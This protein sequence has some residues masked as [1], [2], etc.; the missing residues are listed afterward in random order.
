V[1]EG[2]RRRVVSV[3]S[4]A[5]RGAMRSEPRGRDSCGGITA[6]GFVGK[7]WRSSFSGS[8]PSSPGRRGHGSLVFL[9]WGTV[10]TFFPGP[11]SLRPRRKSDVSISRAT[12]AGPFMFRQDLLDDHHGLGAG[13]S[14]MSRSNVARMKAISF[15]RAHG[16][17]HLDLGAR[18]DRTSRRGSPRPGFAR[19]RSPDRTPPRAIRVLRG[20]VAG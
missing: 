18:S 19:G 6:V 3:Y 9:P 16:R 4:L 10:L 7:A 20:S 5:F 13:P 17:L 2:M 14:G 8:R 15:T 12:A 11:P 1:E